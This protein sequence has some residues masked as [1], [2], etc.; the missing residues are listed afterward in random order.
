MRQTRKIG[1][2]ARNLN[3][4]SL[5][6]LSETRRT[7]LP[8][9][10]RRPSRRGENQKPS[11]SGGG[12][13]R[14]GARRNGSRSFLVARW[15]GPVGRAQI[16]LFRPEGRFPRR[17]RHFLACA[18]RP[19]FP[20]SAAPRRFVQRGGRSRAL[21]F[22]LRL[23]GPPR[24]APNRHLHRRPQP[25]F[26]AAPAKTD[27]TGVRRRVR[28]LDRRARRR[29]AKIVQKT[30]FGG[31]APRAPAPLGEPNFLRGICA[32]AERQ[33]KIT[34]LDVKIL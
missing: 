4:A 33:A 26:G 17:G 19:H 34:R 1:K 24:L 7:P 29:A 30:D 23:G 13:S 8:G 11:S 6:C 3:N 10:R 31:A 14:G 25:R 21:R 5:S 22:L 28:S 2:S 27:R 32:P 12:N 15:Q 20:R 9:H 16:P 18:P